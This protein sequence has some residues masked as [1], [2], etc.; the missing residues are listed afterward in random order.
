MSR[1]PQPCTSLNKR[2]GM[3]EGHEDQAENHANE[4]G[5]QISNETTHVSSYAGISARQC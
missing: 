4:Q 5:V 2:G 3:N 1:S